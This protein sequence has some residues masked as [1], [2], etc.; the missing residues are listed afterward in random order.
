MEEKIQELSGQLSEIASLEKHLSNLHADIKGAHEDLRASEKVLEKEYEDVIRLEERSQNWLF[1]RLRGDQEEQLEKERAEYYEAFL[2]TKE[3]RKSI[4]LLEFEE[5]V[6][7]EK[8][9][10]LQPRQFLLKKELLELL[11]EQE[12]TVSAYS[13][14]KRSKLRIVNIKIDQQHRLIKETQDCMEVCQTM[15][16]ML[17]EL[18]GILHFIH[19]EKLL[20][21]QSKRKDLNLQVA[22]AAMKYRQINNKRKQLK[23]EL[24]QLY[25]KM[26]I[27]D[28]KDILNQGRVRA[29]MMKEIIPPAF[30]DP[31][32]SQ[33]K[34]WSVSLLYSI[35]E[36]EKLRQHLE[37]L[38]SFLQ[39]ELDFLLKGSKQFH[40]EKA[41][42]LLKN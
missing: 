36:I 4:E 35:E 2:Q 41:E 23:K 13:S 25:K 6:L 10:S 30:L 21:D 27:P 9:S 39:V 17:K 34:F 29:Q 37:Q 18:F 12:K 3:A 16:S 19:E 8:L 20:Y 24:R 15:I 14:E 32:F 42:I 5:K 31:S 33:K 40:E 26:P 1:T 38:A 7:S 28:L 22:D 11:E